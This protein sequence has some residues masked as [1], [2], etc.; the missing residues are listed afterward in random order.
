MEQ[1]IGRLVA[2]QAGGPLTGPGSVLLLQ[3]GDLVRAGI[4]I[5]RA[6]FLGPL[7][8]RAG[9]LD[10][11]SSEAARLL[12][13][14]GAAPDIDTATVIFHEAITKDK[15]G[16]RRILRRVDEKAGRIPKRKTSKAQRALR[17]V[18]RAG[19]VKRGKDGR[20]LR[21]TARGQ[22]V[23]RREQIA[24]LRAKQRAIRRREDAVLRRLGLRKGKVR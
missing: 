23:V 11:I 22:A 13:E 12:V 4:E 15:P 14:A 21:L 16:L 7:G 24:A 17:E 5:A 9:K 2:G 18:V 19:E 8:V 20:I 10:T 3:Y 6:Q 1:L